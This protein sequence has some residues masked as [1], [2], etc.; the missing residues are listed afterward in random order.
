MPEILAA[1]PLEN[2]PEDL[3]EAQFANKSESNLLKHQVW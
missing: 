1:T 3:Q 2:V